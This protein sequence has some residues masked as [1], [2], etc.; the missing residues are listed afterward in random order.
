[1]D[2]NKQ[3]F[4]NTILTGINFL[5]GLAITFFLTPYIVREL[6]RAAYGFIALTSSIVDYTSIM[7]IAL[8]AMAG[9]FVSINYMQGN[10]KDANKYFSSVFYSNVFLSGVILLMAVFFLIF[11]QKILNVPSDLLFD[12]RL[13]LS[14]QVINTTFCLIT[15]I[16]ALGPFIKKRLDL[17]YT[18]T[19]IGRFLGAAILV[20]LFFLFPPHIWYYGIHSIIMALYVFFTNRVFMRRLTP[21][22]R[23]SFLDFDFSKVWELI[24][25][26]AWNIINK[27]SNILGQGLDLLFANVF[28]GATLMGTFSL[29]KSLSMMVLG[30]FGSFSGVFAPQ[31]TEYYATNRI[32]DLVNELQKSIKML[33]CFSTPILS[34]LYIFSGDF[35]RLWL[36]G[37][38]YTLLYLLAT[39]GFLASPFTLPYEGLWNVFTITNKL[40]TSSLALLAESIGVFSTVLL[41][42]LFVD[43]VKIRLIVL[44]GSRTAWGILRSALFLPIFSAHCLKIKKTTFYPHELKALF[45]LGVSCI[46]GY[47]IRS[48]IPVHNWMELVLD[49]AICCIIALSINLLVVLGQSDKKYL[50]S[51]L[52]FR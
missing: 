35:F 8:N 44:A 16:F 18:R 32:N 28:I 11:I 13:L 3:L 47:F 46:I 23:V 40:K 39:L 15:N 10:I 24:K 42:M 6:G 37:Q 30:L 25:A 38:D 27:V 21:D 43:D 22:L 29:S 26:G 17:S 7:T 34:S 31:L 48:L 9:R 41:T 50:L 51:K 12:V 52:A 14:L 36:P 4:I 33:S 20:S 2:S 49:V 1:M 5:I 19:I 45:C